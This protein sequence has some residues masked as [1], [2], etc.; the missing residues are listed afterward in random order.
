MKWQKRHQSLKSQT[1]AHQPA[2]HDDELRRTKQALQSA[3]GQRDQLE[4]DLRELQQKFAKIRQREASFDSAQTAARKALEKSKGEVDRLKELLAIEERRVIRSDRLISHLG[5][6]I[7]HLLFLLRGRIYV[8]ILTRWLHKLY[9]T[10]SGRRKRNHKRWHRVV[11]R[12]AKLIG[13]RHCELCDAKNM[14]I[15][16][17]HIIA[18]ADGGPDTVEN[19]QLRCEPC[20]RRYHQLEDQEG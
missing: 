3:Q 14:P 1:A 11:E 20:E 15:M 6:R 19:C 18:H 10:W 5:D 7:E 12:R 2:A 17:H 8:P 13:G 16:G 4:A 9:L